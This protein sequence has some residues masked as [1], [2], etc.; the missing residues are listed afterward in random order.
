MVGLDIALLWRFQAAVVLDCGR[1]LHVRG[2]GGR[3]FCGS[4]GIVQGFRKFRSLW[5]LV[6]GIYGASLKHWMGTRTSKE[7]KLSAEYVPPF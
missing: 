3:R 6:H 4:R 7:Q 1:S 2:Y 5:F